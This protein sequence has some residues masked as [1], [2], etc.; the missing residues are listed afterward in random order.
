MKIA[1]AGY[2][3]EGKS[4]YNYWNTP[5]N[6]VVITDERQPSDV[7][8]DAHVIVG[9]DAFSRLDGFDMVIRSPGLAPHKIKTDGKIWSATNEFFAQCP[10]PIIGVTGS[11]GKGTTSSLIASMLRAA[12]KTVHLVGNIGIPALSVLGDI[13]PDDI[14]VYE[15]SSFQLWDLEMSPHI[16]VVLH[17]EAD[18]L[19]V[20]A[21]FAEYV[22]AKAQ[23]AA[24]QITTDRVVYNAHNQWATHIAE[25][26]VGQ[27][28]PYQSVRGA[29][30]QGD[31]F[32]Y[33][34]QE[35]CSTD[36]L[37]LPGRH[38]QDNACAAITA[39]WPWVQDGA[40]IARGLHGFDG[41]PHRLKWVRDVSGVKYY[42]DSIATT[43]GSAIAAI[44]SFTEPK[45]LILGGSSKGADFTEL[46]ETVMAG[47]VKAVIVL[48]A[49]A[50]RI[51]QALEQAGYTSIYHPEEQTMLSVVTGAHKLADSG[52]VVILSPS[53]ASFGLF[54]DYAD[55]GNQFID[56]VMQL[57]D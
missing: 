4:N 3:A 30:V 43:P 8:V 24:N 49:E 11:K 27:R 5:E 37:L 38:N 44:N 20:H 54:R 22:E 29:H 7:P 19:D 50:H 51:Q 32:M 17:I 1:I 31:F 35:L 2:G 15:L 36:E 12:G 46:A 33:G 23:I 14:V 53:C 13:S 55:R 16:A 18:H 26:S 47:K 41:L 10:A 9:Q 34:E 28:L 48:G 56:A 45:V 40:T 57:T 6:E 42:D 21:D 25:R 52:D 39:V